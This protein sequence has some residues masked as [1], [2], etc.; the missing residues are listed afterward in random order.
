[1]DGNIA[2][3][4]NENKSEEDSFRRNYLNNWHETWAAFNIALRSSD[5]F[6]ALGWTFKLIKSGICFCYFKIGLYKLKLHIH[7]RSWVPALAIALV[8]VVVF[9][10]FRSLREIV[11]ERWCCPTLASKGVASG[12]DSRVD[13]N[14]SCQWL[15]FHDTV[16][17]YLGFMIIF[18]F[19]T[20]CFRSPGVV[21]AK[22]QQMENDENKESMITDSLDGRVQ[23]KCR[24]WSSKESRGGFCCIDPILNIA[25]EKLLV[26][27]YYNIA[28]LSRGSG[29]ISTNIGREKKE[30][31]DFPCS[32]HTFCSKCMIKRPPRCHHCSICDRWYVCIIF[33]LSECDL[34]LLSPK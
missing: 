16:V 9:S 29:K 26:Q 27:K 18:N 28:A 10:Y 8:A 15:L 13:N 30:N 22:Q 19:L 24:K 11:N 4:E 34:V 7:W 3:K 31:Q 33:A 21:L 17:A 12:S 32:R 23:E 2:G 25:N 1:M 5:E 6:N 14:G 20:A